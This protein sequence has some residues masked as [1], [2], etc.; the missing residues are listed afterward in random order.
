MM[1][2]LQDPATQ[3]RGWEIQT[4]MMNAERGLEL[5]PDD[6]R[7]IWE[8]IDP[9]WTYEDQDQ[10]LWNDPTAGNHVETALA[11]QIGELI[12]TGTLEGPLEKYDIQDF[13]VAKVLYNEMR[14][15]E[16][17]AEGLF[18]DANA[19]TDLGAGADAVIAAAQT[20]FDNYNFLDAVRFLEAALGM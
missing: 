14:D 2:F 6:V 1:N 11:A 8:S 10:A 4:N 15:L 9:M 7:V 12:G 20:H 17:K 19:A 13:L 5:I 16:A 18:A 3:A